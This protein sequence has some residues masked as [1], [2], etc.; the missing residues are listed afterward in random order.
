MMVAKVNV[1]IILASGHTVEL[2]NLFEFTQV[3][4]EV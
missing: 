2:P 3:K 4:G 1:W